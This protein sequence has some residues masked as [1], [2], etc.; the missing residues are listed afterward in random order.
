MLKYTQLTRSIV[1]VT[2][3][4]KDF[5]KYLEDLERVEGRGMPLDPEMNLKS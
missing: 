1:S 5:A 4:V 3:I 2:M